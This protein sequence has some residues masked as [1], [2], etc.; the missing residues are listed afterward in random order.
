MDRSFDTKTVDSGLIPGG[1]KPKTIKIDIHS[2]P[3]WRSAIKSNLVNKMC[4]Y[5]LT[6]LIVISVVISDVESVFLVFYNSITWKPHIIAFMGVL[7]IYT[8]CK[9]MRFLSL[10]SW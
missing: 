10:L 2:F 8:I 6:P 3:A 7:A 9:C 5:C 4:N 1:V